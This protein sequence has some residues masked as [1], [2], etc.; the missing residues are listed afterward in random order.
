[1]ADHQ[2]RTQCPA[3]G[4]NLL[5]LKLLPARYRDRAV[6]FVTRRHHRV[7]T[8]LDVLPRRGAGTN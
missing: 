7:I 8:V 2:H 4:W 1:M 3:C 6:A 5:L